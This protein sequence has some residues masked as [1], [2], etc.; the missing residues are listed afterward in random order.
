MDRKIR[1]AALRRALG[2]LRPY[3]GISIGAF[4]SLIVVSLTNL[5]TPWLLARAID[6]GI[7]PG[8]LRVVWMSAVGL[9]VLAAIRGAFNFFQGYWSEAA[10]QGVAYDLRAGLYSKLQRL[11][12]SYHDQAQT[13]Q[14]MTRVT[15]DVE[16]VRQFVGVGA[17]QFLSA[18]VMLLGSAVVLLWVNWQ[19]ALAALAV[20]P[21]IF[22]VLASFIRQIFPRFGLAQ[23]KLGALNTVLQEDLAG[24]RVVKAFA[25]EPQEKARYERANTELLDVSLGLMRVFAANFP[26][27]FF[28]ANLGTLIVYWFGGREVIAG[29]MSVGTLVAF[30]TYLSLLLMP[31]FILGGL[32]ATLSRASASA[33]RVFEVLD[34]PVDVADSP[35][36]VELPRIAGRVVFQDVTF[37]YPGA[38]EAM[39]KG[40]SF[41]A[42]PGQSVAILG[43]TGSGKSTLVNLIPR[44]YDATSGRVLVD[45]QDVRDVTQDSL[46]RQIGSVRQDAALS[47]GTIRA[48]IAY[49]RPDAAPA[50]IEAAARAAQ[51]HDFVTE[52][53]DG[54]DTV[55]GERGMGLSGGQKQRLAI[56]RALLVDPRILLFDD[57]TSSVDAETE[58]QIQA[59]LTGL[60]AHRT[61][62][63]IAQRV[64]TVRSAD[65]ILLLE[66]GRVV[67][68]GTHEELLAE[69]ELYYEILASQLV[70]DV[71]AEDFEAEAA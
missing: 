47:S 39:L 53:P 8:D 29:T 71:P 3:S 58:A 52:L 43:R 17:L 36:A 12:F 23:Q 63:V 4:I 41:T 69:S 38:S 44:F 9:V 5:A 14:L 55:I 6:H 33:E 66:A 10:S 62:F 45:G 21:F 68:Q 13:G 7:K 35:G 49:G 51:A 34:A 18:M 15:S 11:S 31:I 48:N 46:R 16:T 26:L 50:E 42:E 30:N 57:A 61:S 65:L 32:A 1:G 25:A 20:L 40:V 60:R 19:L 24:V 70:D 27:V 54:Y 22:L 56:A 67:A 2:Y 64:S 28:F 37:R 59:A